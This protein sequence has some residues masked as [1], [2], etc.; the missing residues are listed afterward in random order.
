MTTS[1]R[2]RK[3]VWARRSI[4]LVD[5]WPDDGE[6]REVWADLVGDPCEWLERQIHQGTLG[7]CDYDR[8]IP[9]VYHPP[10]IRRAQD[11]E[12]QRVKEEQQRLKIAAFVEQMKQSRPEE[13]VRL[14]EAILER[15][16]GLRPWA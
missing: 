12:A 5:D 10:R 4:Y 3:Y 15:Y 7:T 13:Y 9:E 1:T 16:P 8:S 14:I 2:Q 11:E 6:R